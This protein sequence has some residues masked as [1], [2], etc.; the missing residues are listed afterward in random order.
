MG[1]LMR[2]DSPLAQREVVTPA[3]LQGVPLLASSRRHNKFLPEFAAWMGTDVEKLNIVATFNLLYNA[4]LMVESGLGCAVCI[5]NLANTSAESPLCFRPL[6]PEVQSR[7]VLV[8]K[9]YQLLSKAEQLFL[10]RVREKTQG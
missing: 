4:S 8:W 2:K 7:L 10:E 6:Y 1:V 5:N 9:K 3:D